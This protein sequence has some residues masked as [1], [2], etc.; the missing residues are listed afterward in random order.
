MKNRYI[1]FLGLIGL[2][3]SCK[4]EIDDFDYSSGNAD[5]SKYVAIGN[6]LTAGYADG[7]LYKSGQLNS[8]PNILSDQF[9]KVGGG[10]FSQPLMPTEEGVG[11]TVYPQPQG[12]VFRTKVLL[13]YSSV[14]CD[15]ILSLSPIA[16]IENP[17]QNELQG[18]LLN[19]V[20]GLYNNLG[21]PGAKSF[22]LIYSGYGNPANL[23]T[24]PPTANPFFVRFASSPEATILG[25]ALAQNPTFF[26]L[27]IGNNDVLLYAVSGG[28]N[29]PFGDY[30]TPVEGNV[31]EGF[32]ATMDYLV[33]SLTSSVKQGVIANLPDITNIP[34]FRTV[35]FNGLV[36]KEQSQVDALNNAYGNGAIGISFS[37]GPNPFVIQD[38]SLQ[39]GMRQIKQNEFI[40]LTV[41][42]D[43]LK[44][45][46]WGSQ[47]PI[48]HYFV[49]TE[50]EINEIKT[51]TDLYNS[52]INQL[53]IQYDLAFVDVNYLM[54]IL[55]NE[56]LVFDG[57]KFNANFVTGNSFSLDGI[58]L[59]PQGNA[60]IANEFI[61]AINTKYG[62]KI[63]LVSI[64]NYPSVILP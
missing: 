54:R 40:L 38:G 61:K 28:E 47:K 48:P 8:Y 21:V 39:T 37:L 63:P 64:T 4:P 27:W 24:F 12:I 6:S 3:F 17:D 59:T 11:F 45:A 57:V 35:P 19:P 32:N 15:T 5:F 33:S 18:Y 62:S 46:G 14:F 31:G 34:F 44:C 58:H 23:Q 56:G 51:A 26:S 20:T 52:K 50:S 43:S 2:L 29:N 10:D 30:I 53:A 49:L 7:A 1:L 55:Y 16:A 9:K 36:L 42:Q 41:P 25:D 22:H 13:G 60:V